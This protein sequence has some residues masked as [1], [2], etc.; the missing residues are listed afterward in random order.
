MCRAVVIGNAG[1]GKS[2]LSK[3]IA[4]AH[5]LPVCVVDKLQ[6]RPGWTPVPLDRVMDQVRDVLSRERW[7]ID[8]WGPWQTIVERFEKSDTIILVDLPLWVHLWWATKRQIKALL[9][10]QR[11]DTPEGCRLAS[12]TWR[13]YRMIWTI[14]WKMRPGLLALVKEFEGEKTIHRIR[15]SRDVRRFILRYCNVR[16]V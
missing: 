8:G 14:H 16:S 10:P 6:W 5:N 11:V 2:V 12:M 3:R 1:G 15:S 4:E 7:L 13:M 9:V